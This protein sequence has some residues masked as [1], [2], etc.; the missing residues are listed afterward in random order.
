MRTDYNSKIAGDLHHIS[1]VKQREHLSLRRDPTRRPTYAF[2]IPRPPVRALRAGRR[3]AKRACI[4]DRGIQDAGQHK[5]LPFTSTCTSA[6]TRWAC[7]KRA[8]VDDRSIQDA[9]NIS[10]F[11]SH[12]PAR[13]PHPSGRGAKRACPGQR[14]NDRGRWLGRW[15]AGPPG[16]WAAGW[17]GRW[18]A[19]WLGRRL[20]RPPTGSAAG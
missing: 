14:G 1:R 4:D 11:Y 17:L 15:V 5:P 3:E 19:G 12:P 8:C 10:L 18:A 20:A 16:G 13:P 6:T 7:S 2:S 9:A